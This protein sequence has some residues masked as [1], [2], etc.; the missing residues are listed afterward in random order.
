M[1]ISLLKTFLEVARIRHFG[2]AAEALFVTQSA[3]SAR[4]KLLES[5]LGV[6][7]FTR[8]RNDIRLTP[9]G[10]RLKRHAETIVRGW[11]RARQELA[12]DSTYSHALAAGCVLDL[13]SVMVRDWTLELRRRHPELALHVEVHS[14]EVLMQRL[15][16]GLLD[17]AFVFEP[18]Q[19]PNLV[20]RQVA[21]IPL[22]M[23]SSRPGENATGAVQSGFV[24][25]DWGTSVEIRQDE[26]LASAPVPPIRVGMGSL[27]L[28]LLLLEGGSAYLAQQTVLQLVAEQRLFPVDGAPIFER[29]AYAV[30]RPEAEHKAGIRAALDASR[31]PHGV[32]PRGNA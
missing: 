1:D 11:E 30:F 7:L 21:K 27:A 22:V 28:D 13:W 8:K 10:E 9:E 17:L 29:E 5:T 19:T 31:P 14:S 32:T 16:S 25:V 3:V 4:I 26:L 24:A 12:L 20:I 23:V 18:P 2:K 6:D 15:G